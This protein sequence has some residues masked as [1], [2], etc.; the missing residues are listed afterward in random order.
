M[1]VTKQDITSL[2][3]LLLLPRLH[4]TMFG[5][6]PNH[7]EYYE[8]NSGSAGGGFLAGSPSAWSAQVYFLT[9]ET[10]C[11]YLLFLQYL[12]F[13]PAFSISPAWSA[14]VYFYL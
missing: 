6:I 11:V 10:T 8:I 13:F 5:Y 9:L 1:L 3:C 2:Y 12:V 4:L 14:E 7:F